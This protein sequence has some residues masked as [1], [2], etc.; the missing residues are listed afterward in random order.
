MREQHVPYQNKMYTLKK[1]GKTVSVYQNTV[2][3]ERFVNRVIAQS[4]F[5]NPE[6]LVRKALSFQVAHSS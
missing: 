2:G 5:E 4:T 6:A 3:G 1:V